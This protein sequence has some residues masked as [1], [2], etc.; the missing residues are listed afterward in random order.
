MKHGNFKCKV[1]HNSLIHFTQLSTLEW[2]K[3]LYSATYTWKEKL[4]KSYFVYLICPLWHGRCQADNPFPPTPTAACDKQFPRWQWWFIFISLWKYVTD[5]FYHLCHR[6]NLSCKDESSL[7]SQDDCELL[8]WVQ[9]EMVIGFTITV[10]QT[11]GTYSTYKVKR[12]RGGERE[13]FSF[14][15]YVACYNPFRH[16]SVLISWNVT[17]LWITL[18][19]LNIL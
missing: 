9:A 7:I 16:L 6:T 4:S 2:Q 17:E 10:S 13:S 11:T 12:E 14:H 19:V 18:H 8:Q 1:F 3:E 5:T 15:L